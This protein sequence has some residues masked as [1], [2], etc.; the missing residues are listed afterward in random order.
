[1]LKRGRF[2]ETKT[3]EKHRHYIGTDSARPTKAELVKEIQKVI[4]DI[5][6]IL[7]PFGAFFFQNIDKSVFFIYRTFSHSI[8]SLIIIYLT[9]L[10]LI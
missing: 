8:F 6:A 5:D 9:F 10:F 2:F 4:P 3:K 1:M 7:I